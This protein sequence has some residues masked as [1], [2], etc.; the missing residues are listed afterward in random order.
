MTNS[1]FGDDQALAQG[2][3]ISIFDKEGHG[4]DDV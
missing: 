3:F 4:C 1:V 2:Q